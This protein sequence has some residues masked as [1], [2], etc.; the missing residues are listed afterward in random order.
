MVTDLQKS[1]FKLSLEE[2]L[3]KFLSNPAESVLV[4]D[5][6]ESNLVEDLRSHSM[7]LDRYG[8][9][10]LFEELLQLKTR[11]RANAAAAALRVT[12]VCVCVPYNVVRT[13]QYCT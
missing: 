8:R 1:I 10:L 11:S 2:S 12:C 5:E 7:K 13:V 4:T 9:C 3:K 6:K